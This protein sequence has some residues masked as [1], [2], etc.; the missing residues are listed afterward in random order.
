[1]TNALSH[2]FYMRCLALALAGIAGGWEASAHGALITFDL[3]GLVMSSSPGIGGSVR[4]EP[5]TGSYVFD[6]AI[7]PAD[8]MAGAPIGSTVYRGLQSL[9]LSIGTETWTLA[10]D[11]SISGSPLAL[12]SIAV[13]DA[14]FLTLP[15]SDLY[16]LQAL[17]D[18]PGEDDPIGFGSCHKSHLLVQ[19]DS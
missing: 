6:S 19:D 18:D 13:R 7:L 11:Q 15:N 1:M 3:T 14:G 9:N 5:L 17:L 16:T 12:G 10:A 8:N 4:G 2:N